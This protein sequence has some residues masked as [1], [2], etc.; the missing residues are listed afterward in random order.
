M[1]RTNPHPGSRI[2]RAAAILA[3][4][5]YA[6]PAAFGR[7]AVTRRLLAGAYLLSLTAAAA[8]VASVTFGLFSS[9]AQAQQNGFAAGTVTLSQSVSHTC[10]TAG[11]APGD[12]TPAGGGTSNNGTEVQC[13]FSVTYGGV[14]AYLGLDVS[15]QGTALGAAGTGSYLYDSSATGLQVLIQDDHGTRYMN[16]NGAESGAGAS[17]AG[18]FLGGSATSGSSASVSDMLVTATSITT[19]TYAFT[20]DYDLPSTAGNAY[21]GSASSITLTAHAVQ[22]GNNAFTGGCQPGRACGSPANWS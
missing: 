3:G 20:V 22:A 1:A 8:A 19:G 14:P 18:T 13:K 12:G 10:S 11:L 2:G 16:S 5:L 6:P 4:L 9:G 7:P 15:I 21:Q 17:T